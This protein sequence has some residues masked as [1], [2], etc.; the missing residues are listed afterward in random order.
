MRKLLSKKLLRR[1]LPLLLLLLLLALPTTA[2]ADATPV[3]EDEN[4][5][6]VT[7]ADDEFIDDEFIDDETVTPVQPDATVPDKADNKADDA[8]DN[9]EIAPLP[10]T[11]EVW[12]FDYDIN[13]NRR[14]EVIPVNLSL[15][16]Q[17]LP[18][19]VPAM[20]ISGRTL[21]PVRLISENLQAQVVWDKATN[22]VT[23]TQDGQTIV[24]TIGSNVA[25]INGVE[26]PVPD[27]VSVSLVTHEQI[28]RTM[29][30]VRFVSEN[31]GATV[32][33]QQAQRNVDIIPPV[34]EEPEDE[35]PAPEPPG[36]DDDGSLYRRV[37]IDAGHG[38]KDPGTNG[39]AL[40]EKDITLAVALLV[41][42]LLQ[43]ADYEV[44]MS[45]TDDEYPELMERAKLV[46]E[47]D[48]P[49]FVSIHCNAAEN[50]TSANGIETYAAPDDAADADL[51]AYLQAA[52]INATG[53]NDRGVKESRLVVLTQNPAP[54]CLVELGFMTNPAE[55]AKL[56]DEDYQQLLAQAI[57]DG[58]DNYFA[59]YAEG[60][61]A[62]ISAADTAEK[63]AEDDL[64]DE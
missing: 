27:N 64:E 49:I 40:I 15:G 33:Y 38:G 54:A 17:H 21:V 29:V 48:A 7:P 39:G 2:L 22:T 6:V 61:I 52:L 58:I 56:G 28:A 36:I 26:T 60:I 3:D 30:P 19:D 63:D 16:G 57:A 51:A 8:S 12:L 46:Q 14:T 18:S 44:I 9:T 42:D 53:A 41:Q 62:P 47:Y 1:L 13:A 4:L 24:L 34:V 59:D 45:R 43:D 20:A 55:C 11:M 23:I 35:E 32:N 5:A 50:I 25:L 31:L 37:V 10:D